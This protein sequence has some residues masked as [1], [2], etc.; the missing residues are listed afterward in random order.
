MFKR[1]CWK[2]F[3]ALV[4]SKLLN[5][6]IVDHQQVEL[7]RSRGAEWWL[8]LLLHSISAVILNYVSKVKLN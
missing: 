8:F 5:N 3:H 6:K 7:F 4:W 2:E 1:K